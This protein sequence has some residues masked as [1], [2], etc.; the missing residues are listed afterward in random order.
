MCLFIYTISLVLMQ[1]I[2]DETGPG[3]LLE[4]T[5]SAA[6]AAKRTLSI[7]DS[8][9]SANS[10]VQQVHLMYGSVE[11]T[12]MT[13]FLTISGGLEWREA[14]QPIARLSW[15]YGTVWVAYIAFMIF[16]MLN[17][18]TGIFVDAAI[19]AM[20]N[21]RDNLIQTQLEE[22]NSLINTIRDV[23]LASDV[24]N[25]GFI[26]QREFSELLKNAELTTY[27]EAIGIDSSE[28][29][30]LFRLLDDDNSGKVSIDEFVSGFLRLKGSAKAVDMVT[31]LYENRKITQKLNQV[32][33]ETRY[34]VMSANT[35][36]MAANPSNN[37]LKGSVRDVDE[38]Q[39]L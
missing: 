24:D 29:R 30:G 26:S 36:R 37:H 12:M 31:L 28:A 16:G 9:D 23:F 22:R 14:A 6:T 8:L 15:I 1:G 11:R 25:S 18:L 34:A 10:H 7:L 2:A 39:R 38:R 21:D 27:L 17:V 4:G 5:A 32:M 19:Q 13:L 20:M 33:R 3:G 35:I